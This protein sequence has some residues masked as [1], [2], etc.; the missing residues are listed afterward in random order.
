MSESKTDTK[1][2]K[3]KGPKRKKE[4][5]KEQLQNEINDMT[6]LVAEMHHEL[7]TL[8]S[9]RTSLSTSQ[10]PTIHKLLDECRET[11]QEDLEDTEHD[12]ETLTE[13]IKKFQN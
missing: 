10:Y 12:I 8:A 4:K 13:L 7:A 2:P 6:Q 5:S 11:I 9:E 3:L 1:I